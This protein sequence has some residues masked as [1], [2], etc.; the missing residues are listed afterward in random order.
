MG[1][2]RRGII[3]RLFI[4]VPLIGFLGWRAMQGRCGA[5]EPT[6]EAEPT[7]EDEFAPYRKTITLPDGRQQEIVELTPEQ[8]EE[9]LGHPV[10]RA[11]KGEAKAPAPADAKGGDA[12]QPAADGD[13][14]DDAVGEPAPTNAD[15]G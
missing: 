9:I 4:Y 1:S 7:T 15:D 6:I 14:P 11:P 5:D 2:S 3:I 13:S 8:A 10:P 12:P